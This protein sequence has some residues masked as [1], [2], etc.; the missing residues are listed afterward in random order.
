MGNSTEIPQIK[1]TTTIGSSNP[2]FGYLA[3]GNENRISKKNLRSHVHCS[4][5]QNNQDME[6]T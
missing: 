2:S 5:I 1:N 3:K 6:T 4:I